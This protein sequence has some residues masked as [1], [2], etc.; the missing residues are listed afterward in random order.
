MTREYLDFE[1]PIAQLERRILELE[2]AE[3]LSPEDISNQ[4]DT[5]SKSIIGTTQKIY[6]K[7]VVR[8]PYFCY[9]RFNIGFSA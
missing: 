5:L 4:I 8:R 2:S 9:F 6:K 7:R 3:D 1:E